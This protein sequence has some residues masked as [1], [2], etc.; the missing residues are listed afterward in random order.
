MH[1]CP[2]FLGARAGVLLAVLVLARLGAAA[3]AGGPPAA[4]EL[5][6]DRPDATESPFTVEAGR[7]QLEFDASRFTRDRSGGV[8][9]TEWVVAPFNLRLG[10]TR[11]VEAGIM[12]DPY[13]RRT[14][15]ARGGPK[16]TVQGRGDVT[17]RG[18]MNF[19]GNGGG[20]LATGVIVDLTLPTAANGVGNDR[21]EGAV[22][23]PVA[24]ELGGGWE[25]GAMTAVEST[26]TN[27]GRRAVWINSITFAHEIASEWGGFLELASTTGVGAHVLVFNTGL[28]RRVGANLQLDCG[29]NVGV[30]R[31]APDLGIFAGATRRF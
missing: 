11:E 1:G 5:N 31:A 10:L 25:G 26:T 4:P 19:L 18:K 13:V 27:S 14:E 23:L 29:L 28:T 12:F 15:Q 21:A 7:L 3:P 9:T 30:S 8:K 22:T 2:T 16:V 24:Y 6:S 17:L 20:P